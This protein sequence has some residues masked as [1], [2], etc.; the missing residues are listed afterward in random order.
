MM[1]GRLLLLTVF[2]FA[3]AAS[4]QAEDGAPVAS[5]TVDGDMIVKYGTAELVWQQSTAD[6]NS[7][8]VIT[9]DSYPEGDK[10][11]WQDAMNF[12]QSLS[13]AGSTDW[14][15]PEIAELNSL[16]EISHSY[17]AVNPAFQCESD[18]YWSATTS[19][20]KTTKAQYVH[21]NFGTESSRDKTK[22]AYVRC[23]STGK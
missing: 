9:A 18:S 4:V 8:G 16:V 12:C 11:I 7:D 19:A 10:M 13:F 5:G 3:V 22:R 17:P 14:R 21:F 15:L 2:L 20:V 1:T 23:V 6:T